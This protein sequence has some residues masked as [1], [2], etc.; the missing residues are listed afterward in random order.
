MSSLL[1][2]L[3]TAV[4][5]LITELSKSPWLIV[6]TVLC[7]LFF[8]HGDDNTPGSQFNIPGLGNLTIPETHKP[9]I[10]PG[11]KPTQ[12]I[13]GIGHVTVGDSILPVHLTAIELD[14]QH[15]IQVTV[16]ADTVIW[17]ELTWWEAPQDWRLITEVTQRLDIG[18]GA[19]YRITEIR[20]IN[21][22]PAAVI[23]TN[24]EWAALEAR[25]WKYL[26]DHLS[27]DLGVGAEI[28]KESI[29]PHFGLGIGIDL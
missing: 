28:N 24:L 19:A 7:I 16:G 4:K 17:D 8:C 25:G 14:G 29:E 12:L 26:T 18:I 9:D 20:G 27:V 15:A 13:E 10:A 23:D 3:W 1:K 2:T 21:L 6:A 22:G 5:N 11:L